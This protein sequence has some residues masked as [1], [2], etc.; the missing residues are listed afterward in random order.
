MC[1]AYSHTG[2]IDRIYDSDN[3]Q[4][5]LNREWEGLEKFP[6]DYLY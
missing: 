6:V 2:R 4:I 5:F 3:Y 1:E